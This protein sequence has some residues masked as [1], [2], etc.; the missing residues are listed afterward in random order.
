MRLAGAAIH[1]AEL[2]AG[3]Q[4]LF[5]ESYPGNAAQA[6]H[7]AEIAS[8]SSTRAMQALE[9]AVSDAEAWR[10]SRL[11]L[12]CPG[13]EADPRRPARLRPGSH[14][15]CARCGGQLRRRASDAPSI[16]RA[17]LA[18]YRHNIAGIR[19]AFAEHGVK[20][21]QV[22]V[23]GDRDG[24]LAAGRHILQELMGRCSA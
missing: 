5:L 20:V 2:L 16:F 12:V 7:L 1:S 3:D 4:L 18:R 10:R 24:C 8:S 21:H 15:R 17:R 6:S 9:L 22:D 19:R 11:R 13:C 23:P 14:D